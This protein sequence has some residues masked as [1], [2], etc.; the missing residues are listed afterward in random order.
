MNIS[1]LKK[2]APHRYSSSMPLLLIQ[3]K[4][5]QRF[6]DF[7]HYKLHVRKVLTINFSILTNKIN[8]WI[9]SEIIYSVY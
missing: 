6:C 2:S 9:F 5:N 7:C 3:N 1:I 8:L 4:T